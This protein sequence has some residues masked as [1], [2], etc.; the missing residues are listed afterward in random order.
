MLNYVGLLKPSIQQPRFEPAR[1][2]YFRYTVTYIRC[3]N[4][5]IRLIVVVVV[6]F[7]FV[8]KSN[9][10]KYLM[11]YIICCSCRGSQSG[12]MFHLPTSRHAVLVARF[13]NNVG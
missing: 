9:A 5:A 1:M 3:T 6:V 12:E 13:L 4:V 7:A 11:E 8:H 10:L 2:H